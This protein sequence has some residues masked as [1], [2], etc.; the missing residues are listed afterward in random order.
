MLMLAHPP[1]S[2]ASA[3]TTVGGGGGGGGGD[4]AQEETTQDTGWPRAWLSASTPGM[5][6]GCESGRWTRVGEGERRVEG[7]AREDRYVEA[8]RKRSLSVS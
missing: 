7:N 2:L 3:A 6:T 8:V 4:D 1:L 5:S